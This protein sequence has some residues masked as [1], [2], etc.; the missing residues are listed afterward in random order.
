MSHRG[1]Q[2]LYQSLLEMDV[3]ILHGTHGTGRASNTCHKLEILNKNEHSERTSSDVDNHTCVPG[4]FSIPVS[5]T[6]C[7]IYFLDI[8]A[9][10]EMI[11]E[12]MEEDI[13]E[14]LKLVKP[15]HQ[16]LYKVS[17]FFFF[18]HYSFFFGDPIPSYLPCV[19]LQVLFFLITLLFL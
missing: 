8:T 5:N 9:E 7:H 13:K 4:G 10:I 12:V 15:V 14:V 11:E 3:G 17:P 18:F 2:A 6:K 1:N 16:V 19:V